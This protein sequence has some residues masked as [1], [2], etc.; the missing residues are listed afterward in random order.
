MKSK[1]VT[2]AKAFSILIMIG[3]AAIVVLFIFLPFWKD[4]IERH[5]VVLVPSYIFFYTAGAL[6][7]V[8]LY[9]LRQLVISVGQGNPFIRKNVT[10]LKRLSIV[11]LLL[12]ADFVYIFCYIPSISILLCIGILLLAVFSARVLA[13]LIERAAEYREEIDLTV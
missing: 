1:A 5:Y 7:L 2:T 8:F 13:L 12:M 11:L 9:G 10:V 4:S 3:M 6:A